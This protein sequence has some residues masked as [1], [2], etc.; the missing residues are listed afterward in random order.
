M[1]AT[2]TTATSTESAASYAQILVVDC[3]RSFVDAFRLALEQT[4]DLRVVAAEEHGTQALERITQVRP[5]LIV[6]AH[7]GP[8]VPNGI[9]L[10]DELRGKD[11]QNI[12]PILVLTPVPTPSLAALAESYPSVSV[13]SKKQPFDEIL[14]ALRLLLNGQV[15]FSG[16]NTDP[17]GLSKAE[18]EV[19]DYLVRGV[20]AAQIAEE[21]H[22]SV[23]AIR[24]R[25]RSLLARTDSGSQLEAVS[26]A[27]RA[28]IVSPPPSATRR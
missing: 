17:Y 7:I 19:L 22:L 6:V 26:K 21:L 20:L 18:Y 10:V 15:V 27:M 28:G 24:A 25:I 11:P 13:V 23:H 8:Q 16:I 2:E 4:A 12:T 1:N 3:Q 9:D 5:D 14:D